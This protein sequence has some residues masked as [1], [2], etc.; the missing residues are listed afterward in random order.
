MLLARSPD[1][2]ADGDAEPETEADPLS[3]KGVADR[4]LVE[5]VAPAADV[6]RGVTAVKSPVPEATD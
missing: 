3:L 5:S 4:L 6:V 1:W 2:L